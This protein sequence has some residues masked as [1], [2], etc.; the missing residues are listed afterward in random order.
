MSGAASPRTAWGREDS[1]SRKIGEYDATLVKPWNR[2]QRVDDVWDTTLY[3]GD[4][5]D[6]AQAVS[7]SGCGYR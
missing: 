6:R 1:Q 2:L 4:G 5:T 3:G 7:R